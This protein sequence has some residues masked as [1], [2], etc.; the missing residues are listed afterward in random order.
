MADD[1]TKGTAQPGSDPGATAQPGAGPGTPS[2][3]T[4][5]G[6]PT[7]DKAPPYDQDPKWKAARAAEKQLQGLL[8]A[9]DCDTVDELLELVDLGQAVMT[10]GLKPDQL[11][12]IVEKATT[13]EKY[14]AYWKDEEEKRRRSEEQPDQTLQRVEREKKA[15]EQRQRDD[16]NRKKLAEHAKMAAEAY[17]GEVKK[18]VDLTESVPEAERPFFYQF[19]GVDNPA[20]QIDI[21]D[22]KAVRQTVKDGLKILEDFKQSIIKN[23]L[24]SKGELPRVPGPGGSPTPGK[25]G[26]KNLKEARKI[27]MESFEKFSRGG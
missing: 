13:L 10:R 26:P 27:A 1:P 24:A 12:Q 23:Y 25:V 11:D 15:L 4:P 5:S 16:D 22:R 14:E 7:E 17:D 9:N 3:A 21:T 19:F 20:S 2:G 18:I 6:T 8:K